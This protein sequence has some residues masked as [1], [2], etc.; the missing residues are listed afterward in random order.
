MLSRV[1]E[2]LYWLS[3]YIE[4]AEDMTR[5]LTINFNALLDAPDTLGDAGWQ[6]VIAITGDGPLFRTLYSDFSPRNVI[7]FML[8]HP[9]NPSA[10]INTI[11]QAR[12]NARSVREQ[13]SSEMWECINKL[14]FLIKNVDQK[15]VLRGPYEFF[16]QV[17]DS[18]HAFQGV[19]HATMTHGEGYEFIQLGKH[20]ERA[21]TTIRI[22]DAKYVAVRELVDGSTESSLQLIAMLKSCSAFEAYR[23]SQG[24]LQP[25]RVAEFLLLNPEF[26]RST[27]FCV[28]SAASAIAAISSEGAAR[29]AAMSPALRVVARVRDELTYLDINE[30]LPAMGTY[31]DQLQ[32]RLNLTGLEIARTFFSTQIILGDQRP[33]QQ[34]QQQ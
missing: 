7:E 1:A 26:P 15:A 22:V 16:G 13:I 24:Q 5:I 3:R 34:Q 29:A 23:K 6:T 20:L 28:D 8:W 33:A 30:V 11:T 25:W 10:V 18:S 12:E 14:Y 31:L 27:R 9:S 17:R 21:G 4:R 19:T 2:S 32:S